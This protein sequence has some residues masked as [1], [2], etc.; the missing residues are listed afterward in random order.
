MKCLDVCS[1]EA[2]EGIGKCMSVEEAVEECSKDELFYRNSGGGVTLSGGEPLYQAEFVASLL[3]GCKKR[4]LHTAL[5]T[6]G[7]GSWE[8]LSRVLEYTDLIL[9]DLKHLDLE[10]HYSGTGVRNEHILENLNRIVHSGNASIW[11]RVPIIPNYNDSEQYIERLAE[12]L[13]TRPVE[14]LSLLGYHEWGKP[15]Y[16]FLGRDYELDGSPLPSQE[17][18]Q[19]LQDIMQSKGLNVTI[20]H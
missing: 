11:V 16:E 7:Y 3:N 15:K 4:G 8:T 1:T 2:I 18:L 9:F 13:T 6:S 5:D 14:K 10:M 17:Y 12:Y 19:R 20:G